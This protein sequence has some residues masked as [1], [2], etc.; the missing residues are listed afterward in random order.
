MYPSNIAIHLY[1]PNMNYQHHYNQNNLHYNPPPIYGPFSQ[2][3]QGFNTNQPPGGYFVP[4]YLPPQ[5]V[6]YEIFVPLAPINYT[7]QFHPTRL[8]NLNQNNNQ[9]QGFSIPVTHSEPQESNDNNSSDYSD[10]SES[11]DHIQDI[12]K[13]KDENSDNRISFPRNLK[14]SPKKSNLHVEDN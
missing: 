9:R 12:I 5:Y 6:R 11:V 8:V 2:S 1:F 3:F 14:D 7:N 10:D 13:I 4:H